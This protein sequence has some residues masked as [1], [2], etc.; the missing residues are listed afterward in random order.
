MNEYVRDKVEDIL[1]GSL[2]DNERE[3]VDALL[4]NDPKTAREL[5]ELEETSEF[6]VETRAAVEES[7][8]FEMDPAFFARVMQNVEEERE[9]PFWVAFLEPLFV[10]RLAFAALV[11]MA[12]LGSFVAIYDKP[13]LGRNERMAQ[14]YL[15]GESADYHVHFGNN[16]NENRNSM[17]VM[18]AQHTD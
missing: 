17:M 13:D 16:V 15:S 3:Q 10:K 9:A 7:R 12:M 1:D 4:E 6:F 5:E 18:L 2:N 8:S 11:W 14:Q